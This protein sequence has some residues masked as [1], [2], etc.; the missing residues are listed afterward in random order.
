ME[1]EKICAPIQ[2]EAVS[3]DV[4]KADYLKWLELAEDYST[5]SCD[6]I[7]VLV[8]LD[9]YLQ[10]ISGEVRRQEGKIS[11]VKVQNRITQVI[12]PKKNGIHE[13]EQVDYHKTRSIVNV[14]NQIQ[15]MLQTSNKVYLL[16]PTMGRSTVS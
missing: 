6:E 15:E 12:C 1:T 4:L 11:R 3:A 13:K 16:Q 9:Y 5:S 8:G 7:N 2:R 10:F 14:Y